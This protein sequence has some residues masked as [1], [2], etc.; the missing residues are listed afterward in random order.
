MEGRDRTGWD[1]DLRG[2]WGRRRAEGGGKRP[3]KSMIFFKKKSGS[4]VEYLYDPT[5]TRHQPEPENNLKLRPETR[6]EYS[7]TRPKPIGSGRS[8]F[9][10]GRVPC[11]ILAP[12]NPLRFEPLK[13]YSFS[14]WFFF[15]FN[16][17]LRKS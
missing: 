5:P 3:T 13:F 1:W 4:K 6:P 14:K 16:Q 12:Y 17:S 10:V 2:S 9:Q 8:G 7:Q 15:F 11:S